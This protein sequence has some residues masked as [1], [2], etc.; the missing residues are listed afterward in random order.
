MDASQ[1]PKFGLG[2]RDISS[3]HL[4]AKALVIGLCTGAIGT[5]FRLALKEAETWR[6]HIAPRFPGP[7]GFILAI[8]VG[9]ATG[10]VAVWLVARFAPEASGS[11]IPHLKAVVRGTAELRWRR[12]L[13]VKFFSG[14]LGIGGGM[15]L[16]REGPTIQMGGATGLM[17]AGWFKVTPGEGERKALVSAGAAAG[18]AAAFNAPL[19]AMMFVLEELHGEITP[20]V[21]VASFLASVTADVVVRILVGGAPVFPIHGLVAPA[22]SA[23]P[24]A[25]VAG[26][27]AG[28]VG[29]GF[30]RS[31]LESVAAFSRWKTLP[32]AAAG[33]LVG[34]A[35]GLAGWFVPGLAGTGTSLVE[36]ALAGGF[37]AGVIPLLLVIRWFLTVAGYGS[38]PAGGIFLPL[39]VIGALGG[40]GFGG[41]AHD[42][43]PVWIPH[44]EVF[45][46]IGM[47]ALFTAIV[48]APLTGLVL[49]IELTGVYDFM[50]PLLV[51][52][53]CAY[54]I[55]QS[56]GNL[57][58][59]EALRIVK[60]GRETTRGADPLT[61]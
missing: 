60:F 35:C 45:A 10:A 9:A 18:L 57:P 12:V 30:N 50:L 33:A 42:L 1:E 22:L 41:L 19:A 43:F 25:A 6:T 58:L 37:K 53:L 21:F 47:G 17:V 8:A 16:G 56:T 52:C 31:V 20:I 38:G 4:L 59:Y 11:G 32:R 29:V 40:L 5:A 7:I 23:L 34:A 54:W 27:L 44:P 15:A 61:P 26:L 46:V 39:L 13:P 28:L 3:R 55:A 2:R 48:R 14:L 24:A 49:M 51:S 36:R